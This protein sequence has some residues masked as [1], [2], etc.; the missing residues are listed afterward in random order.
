MS[1]LVQDVL[2]LAAQYEPRRILA[3]GDVA[4][5]MLR[6]YQATPSPDIHIVPADH[7]L[8]RL[9][10]SQQYD[11]ALIAGTLERLPAA[12]GAMLMARLRDVQA[13]RFAVIVREDCTHPATRWQRDDFIGLG[14]SVYGHYHAHGHPLMLC[15]YDIANYKRTPDWLNPR[16]WANPE[17][18]DKYRW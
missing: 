10:A 1:D 17:L 15:T 6:H 2:A 4:E 13:Q 11:F 5:D 7:P 18:W 9:P 8:R 14:L 12:D 16:H 3:V